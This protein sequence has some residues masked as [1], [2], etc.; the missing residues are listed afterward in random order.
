M[1]SAERSCKLTPAGSR[2][3]RRERCTV[4]GT[5]CYGA[6]FRV[7]QPAPKQRGDVDEQ[8]KSFDHVPLFMRDL[9]RKEGG[10]DTSNVALEALQSLAFE[11]HPDGA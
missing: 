10:D 4:R 9:P 2:A 1:V 11:G 5:L 3:N 8:L 6:H 7:P